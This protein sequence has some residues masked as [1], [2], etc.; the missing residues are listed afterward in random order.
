L[1]HELSAEQ[2][3]KYFTSRDDGDYYD[4]INCTGQLREAVRISIGLATI[5]A[6]IE[7]F[8]SFAG[9]LLNKTIPENILRTCFAMP[10]FTAA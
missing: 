9:N 1:N 2:L 10:A 3:R 4:F 8:M 7:K 6:D 5:K